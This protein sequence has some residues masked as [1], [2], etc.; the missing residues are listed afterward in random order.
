MNGFCNFHGGAQQGGFIVGKAAERDTLSSPV[1]Q[2]EYRA[3]LISSDKSIH[4]PSNNLFYR[5]IESALLDA[6]S[7]MIVEMAKPSANAMHDCIVRHF[8]EVSVRVSEIYRGNWSQCTSTLDRALQ[9][10][11]FAG[12]K[13]YS[14]LSNR[15][16][17]D[18][19]KIGR[20]RRW[21]F[22]FRLK[23]P[24]VLM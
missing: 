9:N 17:C 6:L 22:S 3:Y 24:I 5:P 16:V 21:L 15:H 10:C 8:D 19:A 12:P 7:P 2:D 4:L 20:S 14:H 13:M 1:S 11:N 23:F 18:K